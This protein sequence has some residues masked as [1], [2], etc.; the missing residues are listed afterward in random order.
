MLETFGNHSQ[1]ERLY[2][3]DDFISILAIGHDASQCR[4]FG[5]PATVD[6]ALDFNRE[7]HW[8]NVPFG[9]AV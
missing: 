1:G 3:G 6:F 5:D 7:R 4:N 9:P 8:G 2:T